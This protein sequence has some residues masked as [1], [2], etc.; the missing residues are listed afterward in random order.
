M[1]RVERRLKRLHGTQG[2]PRGSERV[3]PI[4]RSYTISEDDRDKAAKREMSNETAGARCP[5]VSFQISS[6]TG[7]RGDMVRESCSV[8]CITYIRIA[9]SAPSMMR[10]C[11]SVVRFYA[12]ATSIQRLYPEKLQGGGKTREKR[13]QKPSRIM[14]PTPSFVL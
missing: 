11:A 8:T 2:N 10:L 7:A 6:F 13:F 3:V 5:I 4:C 9:I 1:N 12:E 14:G